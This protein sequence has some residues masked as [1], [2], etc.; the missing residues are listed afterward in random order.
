MNKIQEF[1]EAIKKH[2]GWFE[3]SRSWRNKNPGNLRYSKQKKCV[4]KDK[5]GFA[6]F[7]TFEA[8][9]EA[10]YHQITI[11]CDG[12][13]KVYTPNDTIYDFFAKYAPSWDNNNSG[14]YAEYVS[15]ELDI[16][17]H[18]PIKELL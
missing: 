17:P 6:I 18:S 4:G 3:G 10:L 7:S 2:E 9:L 15:K 12:R 1:A 13:S 11:A 5:D 16:D 8:G 14:K